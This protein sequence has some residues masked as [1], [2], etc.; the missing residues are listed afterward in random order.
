MC[1]ANGSGE[2]KGIPVPVKSWRHIGARVSSVTHSSSSLLASGC[3]D[4]FFGQFSPS[5][6]LTAGGWRPHSS[7][8]WTSN[9]ECSLN[10][11]PQRILKYYYFILRLLFFMLGWCIFKLRLGTILMGWKIAGSITDG[12]FWMF[13]WIILPAALWPWGRLSL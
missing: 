4:L 12:V 9:C 7:C 13:H 2:G 6:G 1:L 5:S 3:R 8:Q 10:K 11:Q